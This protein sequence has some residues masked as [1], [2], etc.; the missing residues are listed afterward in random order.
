MLAAVR[1][2]SNVVEHLGR[3]PQ[4]IE[5]DRKH[6]RRADQKENAHGLIGAFL[7]EHAAERAAGKQ[8]RHRGDGWNTFHAALICPVIA[9]CW[10]S[11]AVSPFW[12]LA[13]NRKDAV[14][15]I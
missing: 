7:L 10:P 15:S 2:E 4:C 14:S 9:C 13:T 3:L 5:R 6:D 1:F 11:V 12:A 8:C